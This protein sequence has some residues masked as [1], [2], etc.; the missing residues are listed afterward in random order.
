QLQLAA[1]MHPTDP[2]ILRDLAQA[3]FEQGDLD[4]A[5]KTY[6]ALLLALRGS[7]AVSP[8]SHT[9]VLLDLGAIAGK[10]GDAPRAAN[11]LESGLDAALERGEDTVPFEQALRE[12]GR[13]DLV[14]R[15]AEARV[16][17][18][19]NEVTRATALRELA[20]LWREHLGSEPVLGAR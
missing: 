7:P 9:K 13:H 17:R 6:R 1:K 2:V 16:T 8:I 14:V 15:G 12:L 18:A 3:S 5:E 4:V 10:K 20:D 11:L 19:P